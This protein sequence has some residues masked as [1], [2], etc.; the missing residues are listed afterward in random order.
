[1]IWFV[2]R[3]PDYGTYY[4]STE[5]ENPEC[6][7]CGRSFDYLTCMGIVGGVPSGKESG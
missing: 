6:T 5:S 4:I 1:M 7:C 2:Y 3:G